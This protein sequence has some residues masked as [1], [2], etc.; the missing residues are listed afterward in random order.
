MGKE[1]NATIKIDFRYLCDLQIQHGRQS[2]AKRTGNLVS[3]MISYKNIIMKSHLDKTPTFVHYNFS[4]LEYSFCA[5]KMIV[6]F[7]SQTL[8]IVHQIP[9]KME[10]PVRME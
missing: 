6:I 5:L 4:K 2:P 3:N 1:Y 10:E 8:T 7:Y 9:V